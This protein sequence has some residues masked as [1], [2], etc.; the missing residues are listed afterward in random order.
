MTYSSAE[1]EAIVRQVLN[2]LVASDFVPAADELV[3][4]DKVVSA[5]TLHGR[6]E[7][8]RAV[9]LSQSA[10]MTPAARDLCRQ[11]GIEIARI[12]NE[13]NLPQRPV[14]VDHGHRPQRILVVSCHDSIA[15]VAK[16]LCSKQAR[17]AAKAAD[18]TSALREVA[19][20]IRAGH[21][22]GVIVAMS[23]HA[24]CW[25]AARDDK[26]RPAVASDWR[27]L[28]SVLLEVPA[29]V[30]I[31]PQRNWNVAA[32]CNASRR[33]FESLQKTH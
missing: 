9:R 33:L 22:A 11:H 21:Q 32:T 15:A 25:Q 17:V 8:V 27:E 6:L 20:G 29:N 14:S 7:G 3:L 23:P 26:L 13:R 24:L 28:Q 4:E 1:I 30:L 12:S 10:I 2:T 18:D 16:Q 5:S 19:S 31:L